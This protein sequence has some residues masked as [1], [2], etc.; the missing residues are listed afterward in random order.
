MRFQPWPEAFEMPVFTLKCPDCDHVFKGMVMAGTRSPKVW[1]CSKCKGEKAA[2]LEGVEPEEHPWE[3]EG[4]AG[5][6]LCCGK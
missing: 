1:V 2:P 4:H 5:G 3:K 6:C